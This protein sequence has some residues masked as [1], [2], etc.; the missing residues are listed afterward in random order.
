MLEWGIMKL[1]DIIV[2]IEARLLLAFKA[3]VLILK[4][5]FKKNLLLSLHSE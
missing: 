3:S 4:R 2:L 1:D 5:P